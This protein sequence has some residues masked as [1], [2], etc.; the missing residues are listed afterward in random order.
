MIKILDGQAEAKDTYMH[1]AVHKYLDAFTSE[2]EHLDVLEA[3]K[4]KYKLDDYVEVEE[5]IAEDFIKYAKTRT[6]VTGTLKLYFDKIIQNIKAF[7]GSSDK[8]DS[9][10]ADIIAGKAKGAKGKVKDTKMKYDTKKPQK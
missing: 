9:L 2:V 6:G 7:F 1:E 4:K 8:I 3:G 10:Y 5:R